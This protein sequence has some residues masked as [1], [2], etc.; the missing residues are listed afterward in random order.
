MVHSICQLLY[1]IFVTLFLGVRTIPARQRRAGDKMHPFITGL[2]MFILY[3]YYNVSPDLSN[4]RYF[5]YRLRAR[6]ES[7]RWGTMKPLFTG[8]HTCL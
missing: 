5:S 2:H 6:G 8:S 1:D 7:S 4:D 3:I